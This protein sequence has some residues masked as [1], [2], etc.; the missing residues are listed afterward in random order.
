MPKVNRVWL[1]RRMEQL[2]LTY[3]QL[4][5]HHHFSPDSLKDWENGKPP[6]PATFR[7]LAKVLVISVSQLV[8]GLGIRP[9]SKFR[10]TPKINQKA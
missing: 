7:K 4:K 8:H 6:R 1:E 9:M 2:G 10:R 5:V 3:Y